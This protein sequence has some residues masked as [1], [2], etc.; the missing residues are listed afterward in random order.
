MLRNSLA[1]F[2]IFLLSVKSYGSGE[3]IDHIIIEGETHDLINQ[4][5]SINK[6]LENAAKSPLEFSNTIIKDEE[7][8]EHHYRGKRIGNFRYHRATYQLKNKKL[9]LTYVIVKKWN[10]GAYREVRYPISLM[11]PEAEYPL[12]ADWFSG[13]LQISLGEYQSH[14]IFFGHFE[15]D[16]LFRFEKGILVEERIIDYSKESPFR[17]PWDIRRTK[18][19]GNW[20]KDG[21]WLDLRVIRN[22]LN[23]G[24]IKTRCLWR[25]NQDEEMLTL[26]TT[27]K[28]DYVKLRATGA[29]PKK[30]EQSGFSSMPFY[31]PP[32]EFTCEAI[33]K[34]GAIILKV[35]S[36]RPLKDSE[37]MF[38]PDYKIPDH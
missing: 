29:A 10:N 17:S 34:D 32:S 37:T 7:G 38:S 13:I 15:K 19:A 18:F 2:A 30:N 21:D 14:S 4:M 6:P 9:L 28:T 25:N 11:K 33:E 27:R 20:T 31:I 22:Q 8:I 26:G 16:R 35:L 12:H 5:L 3:I 24:I 36:H 23:D 1:V